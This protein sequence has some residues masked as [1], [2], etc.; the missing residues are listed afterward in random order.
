MFIGPTFRD[1]RSP[2]HVMLPVQ[3]GEDSMD[4]W[5][6]IRGSES[7]PHLRWK[8]SVARARGLTI[9]D[10]MW[11]ILSI[12]TELAMSVQITIVHSFFFRCWCASAGHVL[13]HQFS[14]P[15]DRQHLAR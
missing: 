5:S 10:C 11:L 2:D 6:P 9:E 3:V 8:E 15:G 7:P 4:E 12:E 14:A 1:L 13:P